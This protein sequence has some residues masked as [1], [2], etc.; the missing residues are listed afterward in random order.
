MAS[1]AMRICQRCVKRN[2]HFPLSQLARVYHATNLPLLHKHTWLPH[3][4][5]PN[6]F[7]TMYRDIHGP[8]LYDE[9][10]A[11]EFVFALSQEEREHLLTE[12]HKFTGA[13]SSESSGKPTASQLRLVCL[14]Q[15]LPFIGFGFLDN[16]LMI[17]AGE[18]I[19]VTLG[20]A[21]GISTMAAA[22]F[23]NMI[24]DIAGVGSA[25]YVESFVAKFG[26]RTPH[27]TPNQ[28][29]MKSTRWASSLG[30][31]IGVAI[32]CFLGMFPLLLFKSESDKKDST[33]AEEGKD[34]SS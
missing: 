12:L 15:A 4:T 3:D 17:V 21:F 13:K 7:V 8:K 16:F 11:R 6:K 1:A 34:S 9:A 30:K 25:Y 19:D 14:H 32:G 28:V 23:G 10:A 5:V 20:A 27:L 31:V 33:K 22:G 26:V 29:D 24:S 2:V 18:Y